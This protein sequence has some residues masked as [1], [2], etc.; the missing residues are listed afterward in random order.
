MQCKLVNALDR[1][2]RVSTD[3]LEY[4]GY[5]WHMPKTDSTSGRCLRASIALSVAPNAIS[6]EFHPTL[7]TFI[8]FSAVTSLSLSLFAL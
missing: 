6:Q 1:S 4:D 8:S 3:S 2:T 5:A 7:S